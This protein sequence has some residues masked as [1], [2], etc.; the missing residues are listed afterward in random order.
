MTIQIAVA[1]KGGTG[2]TSFCAL[3]IRYLIDK[4]KKPVL[5]VDA[6]ANANLNEALGLQIE[7]ET[8]SEL[9][10]KTKDLNGIPVGMSQE[11]YIEYRLNAALAESKDVDLIVMGGPEG[12]GCFCFPN[13]LLRMYLDNLS[14]G[15]AYVVMDNEAGLE[16]ISRRTT[17]DVDVLFVISDISARSVRSAGRVNQ[18]VKTLKTKV[19]RICLVL[20]RGT[21]EDAE[22]LTEEIN[23]TGLELVGIIPN[24]PM[25]TE[26]DIKGKPLFE[27]PADSPA[28]NAVYRMLDKLKI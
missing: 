24:D 28:V 6:D 23:K 25:I 4:G 21:E 27:L 2:K 18:L 16:H 1:G 19:K 11:T 17:K 26:F 3:L 9:I 22:N 15:Y 14:K 5:A 7:G 20:T 13:N 10:E 12:P 8:V